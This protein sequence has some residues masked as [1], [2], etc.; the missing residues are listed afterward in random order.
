MARKS[1]LTTQV[2]IFIGNKIRELR[3]ALGLSREQLSQNIGV[4]HQQLEKYETAKNRISAGRLLVIANA[5]GESVADLYDGA[6][7]EPKAIPVK[8]QRICLEMSR[9]FLK[10]K[11]SDCQDKLNALVRQLAR[12]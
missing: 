2:D 10:I 12:A 4:T 1:E 9:N 7:T 6:E 8:S 5:L 3:L 11:N